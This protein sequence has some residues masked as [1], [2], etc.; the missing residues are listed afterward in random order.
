MEPD[1]IIIRNRIIFQSG[2]DVQ[3]NGKSMFEYVVASDYIDTL[4]DVE[5]ID[6]S[7]KYSVPIE[8]ADG[9]LALEQ[10]FAG[11]NS[12]DFIWFRIDISEIADGDMVALEVTEY[13]KRRREAFPEKLTLVDAQTIRFQDSRYLLS[14]YTVQTQTTLYVVP[15]GDIETFTDTDLAKRVERGVRYGPYKFIQPFSFDLISVLFRFSSP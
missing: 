7:T 8:I 13:H 15:P 14:P 9:P 11:Y 5:A 4:M 12:T 1:A 3:S 6:A 10:S 2:S